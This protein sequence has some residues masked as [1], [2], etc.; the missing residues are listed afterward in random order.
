MDIKG[1]LSL[2]IKRILLGAFWGKVLVG[3]AATKGKLHKKIPAFA[4]ML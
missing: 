2:K 1:Y 4:V 3:G